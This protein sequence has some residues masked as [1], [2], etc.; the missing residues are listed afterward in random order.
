MIRRLGKHLMRWEI[1]LVLLTVLVVIGGEALSGN[2]LSSYNLQTIALNN[3]VLACL[4]LGVAP[5]IIAADIDISIASILALCGVVMAK[6]WT[7]GMDIWLAAASAVALGGVLGLVN[8][9]FVVLLDLPALAV[10]LGT[11]GA[12]TGAA[13]LILQGSAITSFPNGLVTF[14]SGSIPGTQFPIATAVVLGLVVALSLLLHATS[15]GKSLF[16]VGGA[17]QAALFSGIAVGRTRMIAFVM[18]GLFS[19]LAAVFY[20]GNYNTAQATIAN[21]ELLPAITAV[22]LG[23]VSAYGGTGTIPGVAIALVLLALLQGALGLAGISGEAQTIA[24][25]VLLIVA[26]GGGVVIRGLGGRRP[27]PDPVA[28][29]AGAGLAVEREQV[30]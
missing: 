29:S 24:V 3:T 21:D 1:G 12:Y 26:I 8:G 30:T 18:S 15:F 5:V 14:G 23:G 7:G 28:G 27:K 10:T 19:G 20:L 17:R 9:I 4:A 22:I 11:M 6:L 13:F 16:A 2:L 25:G